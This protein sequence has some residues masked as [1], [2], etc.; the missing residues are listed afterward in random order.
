[1]IDT[2][3][4]NN[5]FYFIAGDKTFYREIDAVIHSLYNNCTANLVLNYKFLNTSW[6]E[7][8]K[9]SIQFYQDMH[10]KIIADKYSNIIILYSG[11]TDS[12]TILESFIRCGIKNVQLLVY[13][14][15]E[16]YSNKV[17][18]DIQNNF[19]KSLKKYNN[20]FK[21]LNYSV[22]GIDKED[23]YILPT[24]NNLEKILSCKHPKTFNSLDQSYSWYYTFEASKVLY[25]KNNTCIIAGHEKPRLIIENNWWKWQLA[26]YSFV[27]LL[28]P[29]SNSYD[30][31]NFFITDDVPDLQI[32]LS[33]LK[34][35]ILEKLI[36]R[37]KLLSTNSVIASLQSTNSEHYTTI[38]EY[39]GYK[40]INYLLNS[41]LYRGG[42]Y[43]SLV[44]EASR[45]NRELK[46]LVSLTN[47]YIDPIKRTYNL[48]E[49]DLIL[50]TAPIPI[51]PVKNF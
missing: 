33:W 34:A 47:E 11:G 35:E 20:I 7:E 17:R 8:P 9:S 32:K 49:Q 28:L 3:V 18:M 19:V 15:D 13:S 2:L 38:N 21:E 1:M 16:F 14:C 12:H 24:A 10:T 40:A 30:L 36:L 41:N 42:L 45:K 4:D 31:I 5:N 29:A 50:Y 22:L 6:L 37:Y 26:S 27:E 23:V 39:M 51:R 44:T 48:T 46:G 25:L 43:R